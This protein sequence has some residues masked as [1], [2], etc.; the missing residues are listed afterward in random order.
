MAL[1]LPLPLPPLLILLHSVFWA[2]SRC[3]ALCARA[4]SPLSIWATNLARSVAVGRSA[5]GEM[6]S[7]TVRV[8]FEV[9]LER[10]RHVKLSVIPQLDHEIVFFLPICSLH[11][12]GTCWFG[13]ALPCESC[14]VLT[15]RPCGWSSCKLPFWILCS[16]HLAPPAHGDLPYQLYRWKPWLTLCFSI[17]AGARWGKQ[18][19]FRI[20][21]V[22][23]HLGKRHCKYS[24]KAHSPLLT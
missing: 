20:L 7:A 24:P 8:S 17:P 1:R 13:Y 6:Q 5:A 9:G 11:V 16:V 21:R 23:S 19:H 10:R 2:Y 18:S 14:R 22:I 3:K 12:Q 15:G 4:R